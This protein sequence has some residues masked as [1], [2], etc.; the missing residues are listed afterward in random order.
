MCSRRHRDGAY[1][2]S[3]QQYFLFTRWS[4]HHV[5]YI[6]L[7]AALE[8]TASHV[9][10]KPL[11]DGPPS[12]TSRKRLL[13]V[14]QVVVD[15]VPVV[16]HLI[17]RAASKIVLHI[18]VFSRW[19]ITKQCYQTKYLLVLPHAY[20]SWYTCWYADPL[21]GVTAVAPRSCLT[22]TRWA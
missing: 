19:R 6:I 1:D 18:A 2:T 21:V 5:R 8:D 16:S 17:Q 7:R 9:L 4:L 20:T 11:V 10:M 12:E 13:R 22:L 15:R 14:S 3:Q